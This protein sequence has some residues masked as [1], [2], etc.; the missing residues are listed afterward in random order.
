LTRSAVGAIIVVVGRAFFAYAGF[1]CALVLVGVAAAARQPSLVVPGLLSG[2]PTTSGLTVIQPGAAV[3]TLAKC[4][5]AW[6]RT[7]P[8]VTLRWVAA[9]RPARAVIQL[10]PT[11]PGQGVC[12]VSILLHGNVTLLAQG[13]W[14]AGAVRAWY[15]SASINVPR[16]STPSTG[17]PLPRLTGTIDPNGEIQ[18]R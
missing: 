13:L 4:A 6:N 9:R 16:S 12:L 2:G 3:P 18:L 15:G 7:A 5:T 14:E 17:T 10:P 11:I 1:V 8:R